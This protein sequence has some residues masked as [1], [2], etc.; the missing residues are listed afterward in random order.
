MTMHVDACDRPTGRVYVWS[1][2][3][4]FTFCD[5]MLPPPGPM[6]F[7]C[8]PLLGTEGGRSRKVKKDGEEEEADEEDISGDSRGKS[9]RRRRQ[10]WEQ[11]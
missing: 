1:S 6:W 10:E 8:E 2:I 5:C 3:L 9:C 7:E 4:A 11:E